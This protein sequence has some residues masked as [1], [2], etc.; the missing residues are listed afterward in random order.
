MPADFSSSRIAF[1]E[2]L[3]RLANGRSL[4]AEWGQYVVTHYADEFLE[5]FRR[6]VVRL[7]Q[8]RLPIH[9]NT[10][11][12]N[13]ML[14]SWVIAIRSSVNVHD[15]ELKG[16]RNRGVPIGFWAQC[17]SCNAAVSRRALERLGTCPECRN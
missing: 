8:D 6:C 14:K 9:P 5:E 13:A 2:F 7:F 15:D 16:R 10:A 1:A 11:P 3:E 4:D 17:Q 12:A